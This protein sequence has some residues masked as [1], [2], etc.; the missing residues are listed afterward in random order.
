M[1]AL[2]KLDVPSAWCLV[3]KAGTYLGV[4]IHGFNEDRPDTLLLVCPTSRRLPLQRW[5]AW[6]SGDRSFVIL[7][8]LGL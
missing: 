5:G 3:Y 4:A 7:Y 6:M 2:L 1:A 8:S